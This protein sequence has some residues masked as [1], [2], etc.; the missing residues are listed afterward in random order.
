MLGRFTNNKNGSRDLRSYGTPDC[1]PGTSIRSPLVNFINILC[2]AFA[3]IFFCQEIQSQ[4][5]IRE[6]LLKA[7]LYEKDSCKMLM[8]LTPS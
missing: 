5:V 2:A 6:N 3:P 1:R 7:L 8:K 4:T